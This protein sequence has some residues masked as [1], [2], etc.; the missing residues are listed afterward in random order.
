MTDKPHKLAAIVFT[1]IVGYTKH[2]EED[3]Q[4][5]MQ[6]LQKQREIIRPLVEAHEG[7]VVKE[8][9]DG[10]LIMFLSAIEAVRFAIDLQQNLKDEELT[11]RTGIHIGD[12][13]IKDDDVFGS[14]VN[15]AAR[16]EPLAPPNGICISEDVRNQIKNK[17]GIQTK[18]IGEK[19]LKGVQEPVN[20]YEVIY[21]EN[22]IVKRNAIVSFIF[23]LWNRKIIHILVFYL[24][25]SYLVR[26]T[27]A[28][29][30]FNNL[31]SPHLIDLAWTLS[32][33]LFPAV[34][35]LAY[36]HVGVRSKKWHR[37]ELIGVP[38]NLLASLLLLVFMF[39]GKDLGA[40]TTTLMLE[41]EEG[42]MI[43]KKVVK[44]D[45]RKKIALFFFDNQSGD[46]TI[47][48]LQYGIPS[49]LN[50]DLTQ[51]MFI[52]T[53]PS[54]ESI[55]KFKNSGFK[56]GT[57]APLLFQRKVA[58]YYNMNYFI[59]GSINF[60]NTIYELTT[61]VYETKTAVVQSEFTVRGERIL[62]LIDEI[63]ST[64]CDEMGLICEYKGTVDLPVTEIYTPSETAAE[65]FIRG[66]ME[67]F[68]NNNY[69]K[70]IA[71]TE[72]AILEDNDFTKALLMLAEYYFHN[73]QFD[74]VEE[75]VR[76]VL[77]NIH[78]LPGRAQFDA[79]YFYYIVTQEPE[80]AL[81]VLVMQTELFPQD[82][83]A[84]DRLAIRFQFQNMLPEALEQYKIIYALDPEQTIHL[85]H[86]GDLY[87]AQGKYDSAKI[88]FN[89]YAELNPGDYKAYINLGELYLQT[90]DFEL[91][92][93]SLDKGILL[94]PMNIHISLDRIQVDL[95]LGIFDDIEETYLKLLEESAS[96]SDSGTI[97]D[98]LSEYFTLRGQVNRSWKYIKLADQVNA[99][100]FDTLALMVTQ[101][102]NIDKYVQAGKIKEADKLLKDIELLLK[103]PIN[104]VVAFGYIFY[105]LELDNAEQAQNYIP[106]AEELAVSFGEE[107]LLSHIYFAKGKIF[108]LHSDFNNALN[109][110]FE[111]QKS[112]PDDR[113]INLAI[114]RCYRNLGNLKKARNAIRI[115]L[116]FNPADPELNYEAARIF[117][118][119]GDTDKAL[120]Y[121]K[122]A[123]AVWMDADLNYKPAREA[124]LLFE[125]IS[126]L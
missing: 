85:S 45:F 87:Q 102:F 62:F 110:Y 67:I 12:V 55:Q 21:D 13:I 91:A 121:I 81:A 27:V 89:K 101:I 48:W 1:D 86:I 80:K 29:I 37:A 108:E 117:R 2:M 59:T 15:I 63:S 64:L 6:L 99:K 32:I 53:L 97:Y 42:A 104:K 90:G 39:N 22:L 73:N 35:L 114:A 30:V 93:N 109:S 123:N 125:E 56:A 19:E 43:E 23:E 66:E 96:E 3:E 122:K 31:L 79:R 78:N 8:M 33:S 60:S 105:Y 111:Y 20:L 17:D 116:K 54:D 26:Q 68:L 9:G 57:A 95:R 94:D 5:T 40:A 36:Y 77:D 34:F 124:K 69:Q 7:G 107:I 11:V 38:L 70:A 75:N 113:M 46:S 88:Y 18:F 118:D 76:K 103:P 47:N 58:A 115:V 112:D 126:L 24:I 50:Y 120:E 4:K 51:N 82:I 61:R 119:S 41:D 14:A 84:H 100:Y 92:A 44:S 74:R 25:L 71:F 98:A 16:I 72:K 83:K 10:F 106:D 49:I 28:A 52:Q 65:Y